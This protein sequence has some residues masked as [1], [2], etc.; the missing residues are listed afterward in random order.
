MEMPQVSSH[1]N[2]AASGYADVEPAAQ[3]ARRFCGS[4]WVL[5]YPET[6][7]SLLSVPKL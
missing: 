7:R 3:T 1:L 2:L 6:V 5:G 4:S